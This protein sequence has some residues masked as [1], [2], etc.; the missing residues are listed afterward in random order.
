MAL[1]PPRKSASA[2]ERLGF[3]LEQRG[4]SH[5]EFAEAIKVSPGAVSFWF[6][7]GTLPAWIQRR[8]IER[9]TR[10]QIPASAWESK[11]ERAQTNEASVCKTPPDSG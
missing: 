1:L 5:R 4:L 2:I 6:S 3:F 7:K 11:E 10:G 9:F 8:R